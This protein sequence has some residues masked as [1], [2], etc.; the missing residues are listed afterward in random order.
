MRY[1]YPV[2]NV[3]PQEGEEKDEYAE[4]FDGQ[5]D[6]LRLLVVALAIAVVLFSGTAGILN[7]VAGGPR[8]QSGA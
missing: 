5:D 8:T 3:E 7:L 4:L 1:V 2:E 6:L